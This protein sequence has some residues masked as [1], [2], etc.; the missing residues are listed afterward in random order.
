MGIE[1]FLKQFAERKMIR[2]KDTDMCAWLSKIDNS[3]IAFCSD[4]NDNS[5]IAYLRKHNIC[6][7]VQS[8][9]GNGKTSQIGM[10][11]EKELW[12]GWTNSSGYMFGV[13][14]KCRLGMVHFN[15][16]NPVELKRQIESWYEDGNNDLE[17]FEIHHVKEFG[18]WGYLVSKKIMDSD[19]IEREFIPYP[20][21][22]GR[23]EWKAE[24]LNDAKQMAIDYVNNLN[25][26]GG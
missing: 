20:K 14:S 17:D 3:F 2:I 8:V 25:K 7:Q 21:Y 23:G 16:G 11:P 15:P 13:G 26:A 4:V 12:Y 5:N 10:D 19:L 9:N 6:E 24:S 22:W 18:Q 1:D